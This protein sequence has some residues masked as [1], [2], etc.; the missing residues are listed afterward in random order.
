MNQSL[1]QDSPLK[2]NGRF[3]RLSY[4]AWNLVITLVILIIFAVAFAIFGASFGTESFASASIP[5]IIFSVIIYILIIYFTFIF[6]IRRLHDRNHSGWL[7]LLMLVPFVNF[8]FFFYIIFAKGQAETNDYGPPRETLGWEKVLA[9][10]YIIV[11]IVSI[12]AAISLLTLFDNTMSQS[13]G[14]LLEQA[15]AIEQEYTEEGYDETYDES[16]SYID[17]E[18]DT[19]SESSVTTE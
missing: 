15:E 13:G 2:A 6:L 18:A 7:S 16:E 19:S 9:W 12:V 11:M 3:S 1:N 8:V 5:M 10:I 17:A 4:L 14:T